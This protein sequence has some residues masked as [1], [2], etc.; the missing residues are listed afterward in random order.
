[1]KLKESF[2][3]NNVLDNNQSN[4]EINNISTIL[5]MK[6]DV[7]I[8]INKLIK[9]SNYRKSL[10]FYSEDYKCI[11]IRFI[12]I[13]SDSISSITARFHIEDDNTLYLDYKK[14]IISR[15]KKQILYM[16]Y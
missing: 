8:Y 6:E 11:I 12:P 4:T 5:L 1:M 15:Q 2:D 7:L 10:I 13:L 14:I 16:K 3:F 9:S